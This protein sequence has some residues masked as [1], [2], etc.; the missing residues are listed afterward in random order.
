MHSFCFPVEFE[1]GDKQH[2]KQLEIC[3][4]CPLLKKFESKPFLNN[5]VKKFVQKATNIFSNRLRFFARLDFL[6]L[7]STFCFFL[8]HLVFVATRTFSKT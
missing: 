4:V 7:H 3:T 2:E 1:T 8:D 5:I 6:W